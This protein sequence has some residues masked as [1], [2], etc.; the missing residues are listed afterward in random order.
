[1]DAFRLFIISIC[2]IILFLSCN[3]RSNQYSIHNNNQ[4]FVAKFGEENFENFAKK[5][6]ILR[7]FDSVN[8]GRFFV[9]PN[10]YL[11]NGVYIV[12]IN[13]NNG[14]IV[15]ESTQLIKDTSQLDKQSL[16]NLA[17]KFIKY[18]IYHLYVDSLGIVYINTM[19]MKRANLIRF[20]KLKYKTE[21]YKKWKKIKANW[22][23]N[24]D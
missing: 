14:N 9:N 18:G 21:E 8:I 4:N 15:Y 2:G 24:L 11:N 12:S 17:K 6:V 5:G 22:Y 16:N 20:P 19:S 13:V 1:M 10:I 23:E 3:S 7:S